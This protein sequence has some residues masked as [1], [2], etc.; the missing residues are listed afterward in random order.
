MRNALKRL[1][2]LKLK[3]V[4]LVDLDCLDYPDTVA[5][6]DGSDEEFFLEAAA[7]LGWFPEGVIHGSEIILVKRMTECKAPDGSDTMLP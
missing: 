7:G 6:D 4:A 2:E 3:K 1:A 5:D